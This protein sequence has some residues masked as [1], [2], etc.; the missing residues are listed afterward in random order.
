[1]GQVKPIPKDRKQHPTCVDYFGMFDCIDDIWTITK[2]LYS[3]LPTQII[4]LF[5][6]YKGRGRIIHYNCWFHHVNRLGMWHFFM[7]FISQ[8]FEWLF[9]NAQLWQSLIVNQYFLFDNKVSFSWPKK[10]KGN[11]GKICFSIINSNFAKN[12][13]KDFAKFFISQ[14]FFKNN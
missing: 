6:L 3:N 8:C 1:M 7:F 13:W 4:L 9:W 5:K 2:K 12:N 10:K 11:F 14:F